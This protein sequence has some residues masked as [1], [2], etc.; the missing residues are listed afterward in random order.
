MLTPS[1]IKTMG[2]RTVTKVLYCASVWRHLENFHLPYIQEM[3]SAGFEVHLA[4]SGIPKDAPFTHTYNLPIKKSVLSPRNLGALLRLAK[5]IH[6][7]RFNLIYVHTTLAAFLCRIALFLSR[8]SEARLIYVCHGYF[9]EVDGSGKVRKTPRSL[10]YLLCEKLLSGRTSTL[11]LMNREDFDSA[12]RYKLSK[13]VRFSHGMGLVPERYVLPAITWK[14]DENVVFLCVGELSARKNQEQLIRAFA[15]VREEIPR[16]VL[17]LAGDG[18]K[19]V[20]CEKLAAKL[21]ILDYV[22]FLGHV[23]EI[24][25]VYAA[26]DVLVSSSRSEGLPFCIMEGLFFSLPIIASDIKGHRDLIEHGRNGMLY[27]LDD[28]SQL[29]RQMVL[30][31]LSGEERDRLSKQATLPDKYI[32]DAVMDEYRQIIG[33]PVPVKNI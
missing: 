5:L 9:F 4:A 14:N 32:I 33:L 23:Q 29:A 19:R 26:A 2:W 3:E 15:L 12:K 8:I 31:G 11:V 24:S 27:D 21:G 22:K 25:N 18:S 20:R 13:D 1:A 16:S 30:L 10:V 28:D 17:W 6:R 7:E